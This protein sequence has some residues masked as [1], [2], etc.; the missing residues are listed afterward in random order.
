MIV[1]AIFAWAL[2]VF[3]GVIV[4]SAV[5]DWGHQNEKAQLRDQLK[6]ADKRNKQCLKDIDK[7]R[8]KYRLLQGKYE[9]IGSKEAYAAAKV[10]E[11]EPFVL[12]LGPGESKTIDLVFRVKKEGDNDELDV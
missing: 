5:V 10:R 7:W 2:A 11:F 8:T 4:I 12:H 3:A 1:V 6:A 9:P